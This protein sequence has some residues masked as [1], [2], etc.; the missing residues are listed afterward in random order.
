MTDA[1][2]KR[3]PKNQCFTKGYAERVSERVL[4]ADD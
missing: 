4:V 1:F 3:N 2:Q